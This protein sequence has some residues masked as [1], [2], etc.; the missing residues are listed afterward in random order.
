MLFALCIIAGVFA[1]YLVAVVYASRAH[2]NVKTV[3]ENTFLSTTD[4]DFSRGMIIAGGSK[5][6]QCDLAFGRT[7]YCSAVPER[8]PN[9]QRVVDRV[10]IGLTAGQL[11]HRAVFYH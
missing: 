10:N 2:I 8:L 4:E 1:L 3:R 9:T 11:P 7:L 6:T 5:D